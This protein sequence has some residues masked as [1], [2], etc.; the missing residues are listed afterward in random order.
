MLLPQNVIT[1]ATVYA[2]FPITVSS[3]NSNCRSHCL[4]GRCCEARAT[5]CFD[6]KLHVYRSVLL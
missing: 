2:A 3:S 1:V 6:N 5:S 4:Y